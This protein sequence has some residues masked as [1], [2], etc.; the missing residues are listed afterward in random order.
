MNDFDKFIP[1]REGKQA[2]EFLKNVN[3]A[4]VDYEEIKKHTDVL[5]RCGFTGGEFEPLKHYIFR[6][7]VIDVNEF[8]KIR[9]VRRI[10]YRPKKDDDSFQLN[11]ASSNKYQVFYG[12]IPTPEF[13]DT[14][15]AAVLEIDN[16]RNE[17]FPEDRYEYIAMGMWFVKKPL[18]VVTAGMHSDIANKN[19]WAQS[20]VIRDHQLCD[21]SENADFIKE[22]MQFMGSEFGKTVPTGQDHL[23]KISAA[24]GDSLFDLGIHAIMFPSV[25]MKAKTFNVAIRSELIDSEYIDIEA[26]AIMRGSKIGKE[27]FWGWY[28][29]CPRVYGKELKWEETPP[30]SRISQNDLERFRKIIENDGVFAKDAKFIA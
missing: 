6:G 20:M 5:V 3:L 4:N 9:H 10:S 22:V 14:K 12:A 30:A 15:V 19:Q 1:I 11:R 26:A 21:L 24:Y 7:V 25:Q 23:Y 13:D 2:L 18:L 16:I 28:M 17:D 8:P 29:Q 27:I